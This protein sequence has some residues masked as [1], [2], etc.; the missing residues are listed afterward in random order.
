MNSV[1]ITFVVVAAILVVLAGLFAGAEVALSRVSR[2]RVEEY[3]RQ[4]RRAADR[5]QQVVGDP[6][7][8]LNVLLLLRTLCEI[9][10][11]VLVS[12]VC[13]A[14]FGE[15]WQAVLVAA[16][17][18]LVLSYVVIGVSPRTL[19]RQHADR[20]A[21]A[22]AAPA[23]WLARALRP[24]TILLILVG[25]A[26]TPGKG[27]REGPFTSEAELRDLVDLAEERALIEDDERQMIHSVFELGDTIVREVMVPRTDMV[28]IER[29]K[30]LRQ[31]VSLALRSGFSRIP[32][33]G[34]NLD[35]VVGVAYLKDLVRRTYEFHEGESTE[36]VESVMRAAAY[37][38]DS[39]PVD[40]VLREMQLNQVHLAIVVDEYGGTAGL[41]TIED[42][43]EEI[44]GEITDEYDTEVP[45]VEVLPQGAYRVTARLPVEELAELTDRDL[46]D[47]DVDT[48]GG[49]LAKHLGRVPI[50]GAQADVAGL[51]LVA[52]SAEGRRNRIATVLVTP[53]DGSVAVRRRR[54]G[55]IEP[56]SE[57]TEH[58]VD[59]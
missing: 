46:K 59:A 16:G 17:I 32:V 31:T 51:R 43:L 19:G 4:G 24:I 44:V 8:Y 9:T 1:E 11:T 37:V 54:N 23:Y 53:T 28:F 25:N 45:P 18:M 5:L 12:L 57:A 41:V 29:A 58:H 56:V 14:L 50:P 38:P 30:T 26:L 55:L 48:V 27:F 2:T 13:L 15:S 49:L 21:L 42:I 3:V 22:A 35:D 39:K 20:I 40:E 36:R 33:I 7:R 6:P 47:D 52:E 10:A 34:E